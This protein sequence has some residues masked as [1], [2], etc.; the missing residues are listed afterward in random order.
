MWSL[1]HRTNESMAIA[2]NRSIPQ[3]YSTQQTMHRNP[4]EMSGEKA[5]HPQDR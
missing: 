5:I 4:E 1:C 3:K 2:E